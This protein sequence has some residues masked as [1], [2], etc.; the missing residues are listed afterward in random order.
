[1]VELRLAAVGY[2]LRGRPRTG[3]T[4]LLWLAPFP[5]NS[6]HLSSPSWETTFITQLTTAPVSLKTR[7]GC[8]SSYR[9]RPF[10]RRSDSTEVNGMNQRLFTDDPKQSCPLSYWGLML[11][12]LLHWRI[13]NKPWVS[14]LYHLYV[15]QHQK[16]TQVEGKISFLVPVPKIKKITFDSNNLAKKVQTWIFAEWKNFR[17]GNS[18]IWKGERLVIMERVKSNCFLK[19][20]LKSKPQNRSPF[21]LRCQFE[22]RKDLSFALKLSVGKKTGL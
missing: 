9:L 12:S 19:P 2:V 22:H 13:R 18:G 7:Y 8:P 17:K 4:E 21:Y 20:K 3:L 14:S 6:S 10:F 16:A 1:M 15:M 5:V 11:S